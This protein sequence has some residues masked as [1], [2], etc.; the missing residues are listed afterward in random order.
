MTA[1]KSIKKRILQTAIGLFA[2]VFLA[3]AV[4]L[5]T[6]L[7]PPADPIV[8][9]PS[10][11]TESLPPEVLPDNPIDFAALQAQYP[12]AKAWL[13]VPG[14]VI[15]YAVMQPATAM[16]EDYYLHHAE[17]G[18]YRFAGSIYMEK[19]NSSAFTDPNTMLYGHNM[20]NGSMF[21]A[22]HKFKKADFFEENQY[23]YVYRPGQILTY[24]IFSAFIN[25]S[26]HVMYAYDFTSEAG[27]A[28]FLEKAM[29]PARGGQVREDVAVTTKD[30]L[31]TL[32]TCTNRDSERLL[33]SAVLVDVQS[34][35]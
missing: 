13:R 1:A 27:Y 29:H 8:S 5:L 12:D 32:S 26:R 14:T 11:V 2:A 25:D 24:R 21:A 19:I 18:S 22:L 7:H 4:V 30:R 35:N 20:K 31:I 33:V 23:I 9:E 17:D 15:D 6:Q 3:A 16:K 10:S 34:T 28:A